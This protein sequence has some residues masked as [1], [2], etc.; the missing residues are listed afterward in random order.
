MPITKRII[1]HVGVETA[2]GDR[3]CRRDQD[4]T[5][6]T[7]TRCLT[8][9]E[10]GTPFKRSYCAECA[11]PILKLCAM[12]LRTIRDGLYPMGIPINSDNPDKQSQIAQPQSATLG[13]ALVAKNRNR[14]E[15]MTVNRDLQSHQ[16]AAPREIISHETASNELP[17]VEIPQRLQRSRR[18]S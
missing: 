10:P 9:H 14:R 2:R 7:G 5:I 3:K 15:T 11:L 18:H 17:P 12:D 6:R 8:I 4:H 16:T 13:E 1:R